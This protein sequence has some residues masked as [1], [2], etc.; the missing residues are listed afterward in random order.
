MSGLSMG[1]RQQMFICDE[2]T[3][4][5]LEVPVATDGV[6]YIS[7]GLKLTKV[8]NKRNDKRG[9]PNYSQMITGKRK[10]E[11]PIDLYLLLV[12]AAFT[13]ANYL[14]C[15][16]ILRALFNTEVKGSSLTSTVASAASSTVFTVAAGQGSRFAADQFIILSD[17]NIGSI[18]Q[19][20]FILSIATDT[21][22]LCPGNPL[23]VTPNTSVIVTNG[24]TF[25]GKLDPQTT[26]SIWVQSEN[27]TRMMTRTVFHGAG[28]ACQPGEDATKLQLRC[29]F[30]DELRTGTS[31]VNDDSTGLAAGETSL[32]VTNSAQF[33]VG[34][35]LLIE[36]E[37]LLV[38]AKVAATHTLT[39]TR[40]YLSTSDV[41]HLNTV[42]ITPYRW[43]PTLVG[44]PVPYT[45]GQVR[46]D[47]VVAQP[48]GTDLQ[49]NLN[50]AYNEVLHGSAVITKHR[51][52]MTTCT[53]NQKF[54]SD[55]TEQA[56][57]FDYLDDTERAL[58]VQLGDT[59][60]SILGIQSIKAHPADADSPNVGLDEYK[61][62]TVQYECLDGDAYDEVLLGIG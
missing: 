49:Y 24:Y 40:G 5:I 57:Y 36:S 61:I 51:R 2:A 13:G 11:G 43:T 52:G 16:E 45:V 35:V 31:T 37:A 42:A 1:H 9:V 17:G 59:I 29:V 58:G 50:A 25:K 32:T 38:T 21:I 46:V 41:E 30:A 33:S 60:G 19:G 28:L 54:I 39:V 62:H 53:L 10:G 56:R 6:A 7:D 27:E 15:F 26:F 14:D 20:R 44:T 4:G 47:G 23:P 34:S 22:T 12:A 8:K 18:P 55:E 3:A 48:A